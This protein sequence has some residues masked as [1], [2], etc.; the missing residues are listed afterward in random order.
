[1]LSGTLPVLLRKGANEFISVTLTNVNMSS[2]SI[3]YCIGS[4]FYRLVIPLSRGVAIVYNVTDVCGQLMAVFIFLSG[5][6]F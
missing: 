5:R 4:K 1:M 6:E 2:K 3:F